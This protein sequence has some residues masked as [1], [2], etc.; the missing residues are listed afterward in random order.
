VIRNAKRSARTSRQA[1]SVSSMPIE[2]M[3]VGSCHE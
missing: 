2:T 3:N 1:F